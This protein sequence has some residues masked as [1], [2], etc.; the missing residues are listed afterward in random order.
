MLQS[1]MSSNS[2]GDNISSNLDL[3]LNSTLSA[4]MTMPTVNATNL[5]DWSPADD[6]LNRLDSGENRTDRF[7]ATMGSIIGMNR[8]TIG[9]EFAGDDPQL[10]GKIAAVQGVLGE[11]W[12]SILPCKISHIVI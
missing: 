9:S 8:I 1:S 6:W 3:A 7:E 2:T 12:A 10:A 11:L 5:Q 4:P